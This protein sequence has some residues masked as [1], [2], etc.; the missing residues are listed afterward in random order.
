[1]EAYDTLSEA[2]AGLQH[3]GYNYNFAVEGDALMCQENH[4]RLRPEEFVIDKVF[5]FEGTTDPGD[6]EVVYAI[7]SRARSLKGLL[8]SAYGPYNDAISS[9]IASKLTLRR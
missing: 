4:V 2:M 7:T 1:M 6:M 8:I 9:E 3:Q 5:R